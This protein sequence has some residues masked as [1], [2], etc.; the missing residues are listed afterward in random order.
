MPLLDHPMVG[1]LAGDGQPIELPRQADREVANVDHLLDLAEALLDDLAAF[2]RHQPR[3][4]LVGGAQFLAEQAHQLAA[5]RS[6]HAPPGKERFRSSFARGLRIAERHAPDRLPVDRRDA[7]QLARRAIDAKLPQD[8]HGFFA[9]GHASISFAFA[10]AATP[11]SIV[12]SRLAK[13]SRTRWRGGSSSANTDSG[14]TATPARST[15]AVAKPSS[16]A[17]TPDA[18]RSTHRK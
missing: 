3:Q 12:S 2:Q 17:R 9:R 16:S 10:I 18:D 14:T 1:A 8:F 6:G 15:A 7:D 4:R 11:A 5:A 13:H